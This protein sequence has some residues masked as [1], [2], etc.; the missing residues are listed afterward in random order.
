MMRQLALRVTQGFV[1]ASVTEDL[2]R[3]PLVMSVCSAS[4]RVLATDLMMSDPETA[5]KD[6]LTNLTCRV[7]ALAGS[8]TSAA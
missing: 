3:V 5:S 6:T 7:K 2:G 8:L 4:P 1:F